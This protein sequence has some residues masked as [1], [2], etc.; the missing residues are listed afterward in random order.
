MANLIERDKRKRQVFLNSFYKINLLKKELKD[1]Y[2]SKEDRYKKQI[3]LQSLLKKS[4]N[5]SLTN[6]CLSSGRG[7]AVLRNFKLSRIKI[8]EKV[9]LGKINGI[10]KSSW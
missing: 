4:S 5:L 8:R 6:R 2:L 7:R 9:S 3:L 10:S 1:R